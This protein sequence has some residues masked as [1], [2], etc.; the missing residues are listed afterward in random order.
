MIKVR[1]ETVTQNSGAVS[2]P[3]AFD[4]THMAFLLLESLYPSKAINA[5]TYQNVLSKKSDYR[6]N[7]VQEVVN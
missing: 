2:K 5:R 7:R 4:A 3:P 6:Q 1:N